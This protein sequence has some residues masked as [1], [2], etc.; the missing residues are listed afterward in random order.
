MSLKNATKKHEEI[1]HNEALS[2][3]KIACKMT[4]FSTHRAGIMYDELRGR[5]LS[6]GEAVRYVW[7]E[8]MEFHYNRLK[9]GL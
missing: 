5:G 7:D 9:M 2:V 6:R 8:A 1:T 3:I 4:G